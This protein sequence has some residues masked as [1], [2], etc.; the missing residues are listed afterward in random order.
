MY[1]LKLCYDPS[2]PGTWENAWLPTPP[3]VKAKVNG[4]WRAKVDGSQTGENRA[5]EGKPLSA[6]QW[7]LTHERKLFCSLTTW[8]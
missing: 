6:H 1:H 5:K 7:T 3:P 8:M 2:T 4:P